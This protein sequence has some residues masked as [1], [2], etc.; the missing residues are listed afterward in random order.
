MAFGGMVLCLLTTVLIKRYLPLPGD[1]W[2]YL[3]L[4][5]LLGL[6]LQKPGCLLA[7]C[8]K[9]VHTHFGPTIAYSDGLHRI[10]LQIYELI[11]YFI[12]M[13]IYVRI[14]N[15]HRSSKVFFAILLYCIIQFT[16]E[17]YRE[18]NDTIAFGDMLYGL[19]MMQWIYL[20][21]TLISGVLLFMDVKPVILGHGRKSI[22]SD[23]SG[24]LLLLFTSIL[25]YASFRYLYRSEVIAIKSR[26]Y[27]CAVFS[28]LDFQ[29]EGFFFEETKMVCICLILHLHYLNESDIETG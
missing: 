10:P 26:I 8:C 3:G 28:I 12:A 24:L 21:C 29:L 14:R 4:A 27:S 13:W 15:I 17:F 19:K 25:F 11:L 1:F 23:S 20:S 9:G 2:Y 18:P 7:G 16:L 5:I 22:P 6:I